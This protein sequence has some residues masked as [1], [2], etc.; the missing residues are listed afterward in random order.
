[1]SIIPTQEAHDE[2]TNRPACCRLRTKMYYVIGRHDVDLT[3]SSPSAQY[4][5]ALTTTV[6]GPDDV[7]ASPESCR[8]HRACFETD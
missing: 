4:W 5:C 2:P 1:M 7:C 6:L 8:T 3:A